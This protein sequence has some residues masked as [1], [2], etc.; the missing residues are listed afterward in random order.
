MHCRHT[1]AESYVTSPSPG[2]CEPTS[3]TPVPLAEDQSRR[4]SPGYFQPTS[5]TPATEDETRH[6][7]SPGGSELTSSSTPA[8][9]DQTRSGS[10]GHCQSKSSTPA[11][12]DPDEGGGNLDVMN[13]KSDDDS[14]QDLSALDSNIP[15]GSLNDPMVEDEADTETVWCLSRKRKAAWLALSRGDGRDSKPQAHPYKKTKTVPKQEPSRPSKL[16]WK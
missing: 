3:S 13:T 9:E 15:S 7:V 10:P 14:A 6:S 5:S 2:G 1:V 12:E 8:P 11:P 4:V 16:K